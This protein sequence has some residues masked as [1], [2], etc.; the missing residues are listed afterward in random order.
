MTGGTVVADPWEFC[1]MFT[2]TVEERSDVLGLSGGK[3]AGGLKGGIV[4]GVASSN[5][6]EEHSYSGATCSSTVLI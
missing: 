6:K 3:R 4:K 2:L 1:V 5:K